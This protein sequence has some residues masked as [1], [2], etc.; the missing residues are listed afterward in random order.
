MSAMILEQMPDT[1]G[2]VI[3]R[4]EN[5]NDEKNSPIRGGFE[6][7]RLG[8]QQSPPA[9]FDI[10]RL[11]RRRVPKIPGIITYK[12]LQQLFKTA[13]EKAITEYLYTY[14]W[15]L[16]L[17]QAFLNSA[18]GSPV[19]YLKMNCSSLFPLIFYRYQ[20][21]CDCLP[22]KHANSLTYTIMLVIKR[23][24]QSEFQLFIITSFIMTSPHHYFYSSSLLPIIY[25]IS[26]ITDRLLRTNAH[27][28]NDI[29]LHSITDSCH[30]SHH[31]PLSSSAWWRLLTSPP[32]H[33]SYCRFI[34]TDCSDAM[35]TSMT[36]QVEIRDC[37]IGWAQ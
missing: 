11:L 30:Y 5:E 13:G 27:E 7:N 10:S 22:S 18:E 33:Y 26:S 25:S 9:W 29:N 6:N 32:R 1:I 31:F 4:M 21:H 8:K 35:S 28:R 15:N 19:R 36:Q 12:Y 20:V 2:D 17:C 3:P 16:G 34:V 14:G 23:C 24:F 37:R